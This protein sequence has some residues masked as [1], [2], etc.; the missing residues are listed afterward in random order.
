MS[1][2][3]YDTASREKRELVPVHEGQ[4]GIY[5]C[6][7]TVQSAPHVG[8]IR[9][10]VAFDVLRRWLEQAGLKVRLVANIT[11]IDDKVLVKSAERGIEWWELA[12]AN[13]RR[14]HEAYETLGCLPP[15]YEPRATGHIPEMLE[16]VETL[17]D[18]GHAYAAT[19]GSGDVYF[20]VRSWPAYGSLSRMRIDD[21]EPAADADPR[22]KRD[23]RDFALWKGHKPD[24]PATASWA[25][26]W[27][28]G[29]P[30]WHLECSAM[31]AKYLG[32]EF[33]IHG[34]GLDLR[35]PHHE[36]EL[37]QSSAAGQA[38]A[39]LWMHNAMV[40]TAGEKMSKSMG[41]SALVSE[42]VQRFRPV[43]LRYYLV[44]PHYRSIVEFSDE[45]L[46]ES[47]AAYRRLEGYVT[48]ATEV[49]GGVDVTRG[50]PCGD[51]VT[52]MDDDLS[53]P[54][55]LAAIHDVVHEGNRLLAGGDSPAL[56]GNLASVRRML[57]LLGLDP[58]HPQWS[59][60][61]DTGAAHD[62]VGVLVEALLQQRQDARARKDWAAADAVRDQLK[63]AGIEIEDTSAGPRWTL[64]GS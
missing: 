20:D 1:L 7:L 10:E 56:Q 18:K 51:F 31:A 62:T 44:A 52:A 8:H 33:D 5:H 60:D 42:V 16:M 34:G 45:S 40:T 32:D 35:F 30:G 23:P 17:M 36:N 4:V 3:L 46:A 27:G 13:E 21:M 64:A 50:I 24:E 2:R 37:A 38:F 57:D 14:L 53:T 6:G 11:D 43:E 59:A 58:L 15:A 19:D 41:N 26:P 29:R 49:T 55:A 22:G 25:S 12:Y 48:R 28:R 54:A 61:A 47:A 39:R 63:A 9:K